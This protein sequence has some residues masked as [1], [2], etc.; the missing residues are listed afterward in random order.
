MVYGS[1]NTMTYLKP[2]KWYMYPFQFIARCQSKSIEEQYE[3]Y[4][5]RM[6]DLR[7][8]YD[9]NLDREF[10][11]GAMAYKGDVIKVLDYL[12]DKDVYVRLTLEHN[13]KDDLKSALV[14]AC[15]IDDC[16]KWEEYYPGIK[17]FNGRRKSDWKQLYKF[18]ISDLE[19]TQMV[20]SMTGTKLDDW[21]PWIYAKTHNKSN[22]KKYQDVDY[23]LMDFVHDK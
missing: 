13:D 3:K 10:R 22:Y 14:E 21:W 20:S 19:I 4:G 18:K 17:F 9:N 6:F 12:R 1:H 11:H 16:K 7:I 15:F 2:K 23:L 8:A 5:V